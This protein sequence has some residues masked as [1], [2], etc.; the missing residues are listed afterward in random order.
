MDEQARVQAALAAADEAMAQF[1]CRLE[2][3]VLFSGP[4]LQ[5]LQA[6]GIGID[7]TVVPNAQPQMQ[8]MATP[9]EAEDE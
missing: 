5:L 4:A 3:R 8:M 1:G 2:P 7:L 9:T 6:M